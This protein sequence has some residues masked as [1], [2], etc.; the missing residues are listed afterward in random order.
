M[1]LSVGQRTTLQPGCAPRG[2]ALPWIILTVAIIAAIA[3]VVAP[4]LTTLD[5]RTRALNSAT[6]LKLIADGF[7]Q[8]GNALNQYPGHV[9]QLTIPITTSTTNTCGQTMSATDVTQWTAN[10][11]Y[12]PIYTPTNGT[13]TDIGRIRDSVPFRSSPPVKTPIYVELPG[14]SGE[15][16][17]MLK[18]VVDNGT[19]DTVSFAAAINDTTTVRYRVLSS[20][21]IINNRC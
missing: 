11:P 10:A 19:G 9:S 7:I 21:V 20:G 8:F 3:A 16:A 13:W 1:N 15:D 2:Y 6:Q 4:S 18:N 17:A 5:D 14:V 12:A